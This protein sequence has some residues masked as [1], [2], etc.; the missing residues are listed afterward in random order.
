MWSGNTKIALEE[1]LFRNEQFADVCV[2]QLKNVFF[3]ECLLGCARFARHSDKMYSHH[4][5]SYGGLPT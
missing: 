3:F 5:F 1:K 4:H 2:G